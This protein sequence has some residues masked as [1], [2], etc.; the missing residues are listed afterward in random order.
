M[1]ITKYCTS[2]KV[3]TYEP[4]IL[5]ICIVY[6]TDIQSDSNINFPTIYN[7]VLLIPDCTESIKN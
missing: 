2:T 3:K 7:T 4:D 5:P 6:I 1:N